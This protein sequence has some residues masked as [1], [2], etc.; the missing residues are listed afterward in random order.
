M[1]GCD[2]TTPGLV[3]G[4]T[5]ADIPSVFLPAGPMLKGNFSGTTLGSGTDAWKYW[6]ERCAGNLDECALARD[7]TGHCPLAGSLHDHGHGVDDEQRR[8][9]AWSVAAGR[10]SIPAVHSAPHSRLAELCGRRA[11]EIAWEDLR[12]SRLLSARPSTTPSSATWPLAGQPT[13]LSI[14]LPWPAGLES[15]CR[16][17]ALT[18]FRIARRSSPICDRPVIPDGGFLRRWR[19]AR[20]ARPA[21][22]AAETGLPHNQR[23][24]ARR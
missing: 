7:R 18:N 21:C 17:I 6:A 2:K 4:A 24:H 1:G 11:V 9:N 8:R 14:S 12:P 16:S 10:S 15:N 19:S 5:S 20:P 3:M 22:P 13:R 23:P